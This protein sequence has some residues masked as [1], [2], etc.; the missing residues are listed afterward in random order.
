MQTPHR[1]APLPTPPRLWEL[2]QV[3]MVF[4]PQRVALLVCISGLSFV[5]VVLCYMY[6]VFI[7]NAS[8]QCCD[9]MDKNKL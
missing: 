7:H 9:I 3:S 6:L 4:G 8:M 1:K 2:A 5:G